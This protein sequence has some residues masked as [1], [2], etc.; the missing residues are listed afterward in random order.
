MM[1]PIAKPRVEPASSANE[2]ASHGDQ[3][4]FTVSAHRSVESETIDPTERSIPPVRMTN[5]MPTATTSRKE[6]STNRLRKT[7][8]LKK[9]WSA[10]RNEPTVNIVTKRLKLARI[11]TTL[12]GMRAPVHRAADGASTTLMPAPPADVPADGRRKAP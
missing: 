3:P 9:S 7:W 1:Q 8:A 6:L 12:A 4:A 2:K 10:Y 5:V 11:G